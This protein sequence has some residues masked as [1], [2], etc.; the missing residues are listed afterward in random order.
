MDKVFYLCDRKSCDK[1]VLSTEDNF[2]GA[3]HC[4]YIYTD[5]IECAKNFTVEKIYENGTEEKAFIE[6][7]RTEETNNSNQHFS[8]IIFS[9]IALIIAIVSIVIHFI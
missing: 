9:T 7:Y 2:R 6:K 1:C 4:K 3:E 5:N 8:D